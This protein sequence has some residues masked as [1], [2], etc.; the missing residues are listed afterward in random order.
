MTAYLYRRHIMNKIILASASPRRKELLTQIGIHYKVMPCTI[1]EK[2]T[3]TQ[4]EEVVAQLS[5]QKATDVCHRLEAQ[6]IGRAHV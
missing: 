4:P 1:E 2:I 5:H 3:E 6:E